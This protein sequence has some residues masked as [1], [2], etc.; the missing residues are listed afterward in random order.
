[1]NAETGQQTLDHPETTAQL[2]RENGAESAVCWDEFRALVQ[3]QLDAF[4][5]E[6]RTSV[7]QT[8]GHGPDFW[9]ALGDS[10]TGGKWTRPRLV[11]IAYRAGSGTDTFSCARLAASFE[12][13]H[14]AL[15]IHDDVIDRDFIRRGHPTLSAVYR[16]HALDLGHGLV[17][18]NHAGASAAIIAG[19]LLLAGSIR[20]SS[21]AA[22][23]GPDPV[24]VIN[25]MS[26]AVLRSATGELDDLL[27]SLLPQ[28]SSVANVL[29]MERLKTAAYSFEAPLI[30]G[31]LLSG[32][33]PATAERLGAVGRQIGIAYQITD[34]VLGTF[35]DP[36]ITGKSVDS[37]LLEGKHTI[38][39]AYA[40]TACDF[41]THWEQFH[42]GALDIEELRT[43]L[44]SCG[45]EEYART[46]AAGI[47]AEAVEE[48]AQLPLSDTV[49]TELLSIA[50][51]AINRGK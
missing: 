18:A 27:Y 44:R 50:H 42:Q 26:T 39:S 36:R 35:G 7:N 20:F 25:A 40:A 22:V 49:R 31:S 14:A 3:A 4:L 51:H 46:L 9:D 2:G 8:H 19:D 24:G 17:D 12:L 10:L 21:L 29:D 43:L 5:E 33:S 1:M 48:L 38:L 23:A 11:W 45:A 47:I 32:A 41:D 34:D 15:L 28:T 13:L 30:A 6:S 37:D 16:D